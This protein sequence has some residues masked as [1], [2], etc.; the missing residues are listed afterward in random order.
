MARRTP[1]ARRPLHATALLLGLLLVLTACVDGGG[2]ATP[3]ANEPT[4][5]T[6]PTESPST[7]FEIPLGEPGPTAYAHLQAYLDVIVEPAHFDECLTTDPDTEWYKCL[8]GP[9]TGSGLGHQVHRWAADQFRRIDGLEHIQEQPFGFPIFKPRNYE[10]TV[11]LADGSTYR[12]AVFPW[13]FQG[14]TPPQGVSGDLVDLGGG[15]LLDRLAAGDV[16]GKVIIF[17]ARQVLNAATVGAQQAL[18]W[19]AEQGAIGAIVAVEGPSNELVAQNYNTFEGP[20][21]LPTL[22]VG[23]FDGHRLVELAGQPAQLVVDADIAEPGPDGYSSNSYAFLPGVNRDQF[24]VIGTPVNGWFTVGSERGPGV[25]GLIYLARYLADRV[26]R[27][28]PLPY[29]V[30]F[31]FTGAHEMLGFGQERVLQCLGPE[32][33]A[34]YVHLGA[35]LASRGYIERQGEPVPT[36]LPAT[37]R[38]LVISENP[39]LETATLA[40]FADVIATQALTVSP[41]GVF[42]PGETQAAYALQIPTLGIS[43]AGLFHHSPADT[44]DKLSLDYLAPVIESY[45]DLVDRLLDS[46]PNSLRNA[47]AVA[48]ALAGDPIGYSCPGPITTP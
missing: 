33:V 15:S 20:R 24:L 45:R 48:D 9:R 34:T 21:S 16:S 4:D 43:G 39:L 1:R 19:A 38:A 5:P 29:T 26:R 8:P 17:T 27:E 32:R 2:D 37:Q 36:G 47:N 6:D 22:I 35:G 42:N 25:G 7:G 12:P 23:E 44:I 41:G 11:S 10:L 3:V 46:D 14:V 31:T 18:D 28:G 13:Y 40:A 30:V